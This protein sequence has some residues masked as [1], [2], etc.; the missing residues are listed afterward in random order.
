ME[1]HRLLVIAVVCI[2]CA[3]VVCV[4]FVDHQ[5]TVAA[6]AEEKA[7]LASLSG[8]EDAEHRAPAGIRVGLFEADPEEHVATT[9]LRKILNGEPSFAWEEF[10]TA[11][12]EAETLGR[13][14]VIIFPGGSA[15][16]QLALLGDAGTERVRNFVQSGGGYVG[17]CAGAYVAT[18]KYERGLAIINAK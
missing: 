13:F 14:D 7:L 1:R 5:R 11:D 12:I 9:D 4:A 8:A 15:A 16:E 18:A 2:C 17:I 3:A 10:S 6:A